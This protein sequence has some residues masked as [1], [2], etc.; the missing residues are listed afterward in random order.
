MSKKYINFDDDDDEN[1]NLSTEVEEIRDIKNN[2][3]SSKIKLLGSFQV[4]QFFQ[5][6]I[7]IEEQ[8]SFDLFSNEEEFYKDFANKIN[9]NMRTVFNESLPKYIDNIKVIDENKKK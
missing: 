1:I 7:E 9:N 8:R 6:A 5:M 4:K 2:L 3:I